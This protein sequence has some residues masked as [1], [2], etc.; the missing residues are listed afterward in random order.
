MMPGPIGR[1]CTPGSTLA[2]RPVRP[3]PP[4]PPN[5]TIVAFPSLP[6]KSTLYDGDSGGFAFQHQ[7]PLFHC[8]QL[9]RQRI[10][11]V[12]TMPRCVKSPPAHPF[13]LPTHPPALP[14]LG[15]GLLLCTSP[16]PP[17][18]PPPHPPTVLYKHSEPPSPRTCD[19]SPYPSHLLTPKPAMTPGPQ[20]CHPDLPHHPTCT[21]ASTMTAL[22]AASTFL[23][24]QN[25]HHSPSLLSPHYATTVAAEA[26]TLL[27]TRPALPWLA[28]GCRTPVT[29][30]SPPTP[31]PPQHVLIAH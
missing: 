24:I 18:P 13:P 28:G 16:P 9:N 5:S 10:C 2:V 21:P 25:Q 15:W 23:N 14:W 22:L 7:P 29:P 11:T 12:S 8:S 31:P 20:T 6:N 1:T 26:A 27:T 30:P 3:P 4:L 19:S 17:S